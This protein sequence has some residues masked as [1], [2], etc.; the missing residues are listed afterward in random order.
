MPHLNL[1]YPLPVFS[2][3]LNY[4]LPVFSSLLNS[5]PS[6]SLARLYISFTEPYMR[7]PYACLGLWLEAGIYSAFYALRRGPPPGTFARLIGPRISSLTKIG[8]NRTLCSN[9]LP[10]PE[11]LRRRQCH[12]HPQKRRL[13]KRSR[14]HQHPQELEKHLHWYR[15]DDQADPAPNSRHP[16]S[17]LPLP[18]RPHFPPPSPPRSDLLRFSPFSS[19]TPSPPYSAIPGDGTVVHGL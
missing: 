3:L 17:T 11:E 2:S 10:L 12:L 16:P 13:E 8:L 5:G 18:C 9:R 15:D 14:Q 7:S 1:N 6:L 4:P 19:C